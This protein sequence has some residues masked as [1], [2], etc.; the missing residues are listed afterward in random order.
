MLA[1]TIYAHTRASHEENED[2]EED[3]RRNAL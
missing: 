3:M 2:A 1:S